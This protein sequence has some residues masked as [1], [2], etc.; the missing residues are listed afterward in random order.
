MHKGQHLLKPVLLS[1]SDGYILDIQGSYFSDSRNNDAQLFRN[2]FERDMANMAES[3]QENDIVIVD[4]GYQDAIP[5]LERFG[6]RYKMPPVLRRGERQLT[7]EDANDA[8]LITK[9]R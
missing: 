9:T 8:R 1:A 7:T 4:Q 6:I 3:I 5:L 2:E